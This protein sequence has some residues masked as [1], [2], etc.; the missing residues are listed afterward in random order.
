MVLCYITVYSV[1]GVVW[2]CFPGGWTTAWGSVMLFCC[3]HVVMCVGM[4]STCHMT[5]GRSQC[6]ALIAL[7]LS[8]SLCVL[9][10]TAMCI[11]YCYI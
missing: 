4:G 1:F 10:N 2:D 8:E 11:Q 5:G 7:S 6:F 3:G 9:Y